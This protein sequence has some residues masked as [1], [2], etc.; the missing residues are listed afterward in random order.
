MSNPRISAG[1]I[2]LMALGKLDELTLKGKKEPKL[3]RKI[4]YIINCANNDIERLKQASSKCKHV[5]S[6]PT[7]DKETSCMVCGE[8]LVEEQQSNKPISTTVSKLPPPESM[9]GA[10]DGFPGS[11]YD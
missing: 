7:F 2:A 6:S 5:W 11:D 3:H 1:D 8:H 4:R 9:H 10:A